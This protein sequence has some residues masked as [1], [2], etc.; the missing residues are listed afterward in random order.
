M[1]VDLLQSRG[2]LRTIG[3]LF[4]RPTPRFLRHILLAGFH[5][6]RR[7]VEKSEDRDEG[8]L[9]PFCRPGLAPTTSGN[10]DR[11]SMTRDA[12]LVAIRIAKVRAVVVF[13]VLRAKAWRALAGSAMVQR[14]LV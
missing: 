2:S 6:Q 14:N 12:Q 7:S 9:W 4:Q 3:I 10:V 11:R 5:R 13:V 1:P 8:R